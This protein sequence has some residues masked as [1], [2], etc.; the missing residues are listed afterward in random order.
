M[1]LT[2]R[3]PGT[4]LK[5]NYVSVWSP[6]CRSNVQRQHSAYK[7]ITCAWYRIYHIHIHSRLTHTTKQ[8]QQPCLLFWNHC[9]IPQIMKLRQIISVLC[10][11]WHYHS[12][13]SQYVRPPSI[14]LVGKITKTSKTMLPVPLDP[15]IGV[16]PDK[17]KTIIDWWWGYTGVLK[18][19]TRNTM[20]YTL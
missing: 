9:W 3:W 10:S 14:G 17:T 4:Q 13:T 11:E 18:K 19:C 12:V 1:S 2:S 15:S 5:M 6:F 8:Q 20:Y 7:T 16:K